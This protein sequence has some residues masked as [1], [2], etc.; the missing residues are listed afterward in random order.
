MNKWLLTVSWIL[1]CCSGCLYQIY[2]LS[3]QYMRYEV[4]TNVEIF[5]K[6]KI[7]LPAVTFCF[8]IIN[9]ID[10]SNERVKA[11]CKQIIPKLASCVNMTADQLIA[12]NRMDH[13]VASDS[14]KTHQILDLFEIP[15]IIMNL[16]VRADQMIPAHARFD[17]MKK[18]LAS[19]KELTD[20]FS[21]TEYIVANFKCITL[22]WLPQHAHQEYWF[23]KR[24]ITMLDAF[25]FIVFDKGRFDRAH[26][27]YILYSV[28]SEQP[29]Y[30]TYGY[31]L[32]TNQADMSKANYEVFESKIMPS[33]FRTN[34]MDYKAATDGR[35]E[36]RASCFDDCFFRLTN[37]VDVGLKPIPNRMEAN[38]FGLKSTTIFHPGNQEVQLNA[39]IECQERCSHKDCHQKWYNIAEKPLS[40]ITRVDKVLVCLLPSSPVVKSVSAAKVTLESYLTDVTSTFGFWLGFSVVS[41]IE[42]M[43]QLGQRLM[44]YLFGLSVNF[45]FCKGNW[46]R[47][48]KKLMFRRIGKNR[49]KL[50]V[51]GVTMP[52]VQSA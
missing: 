24:E 41:L 1:I 49:V 27:M 2:I 51:T 46:C 18:K 47:K 29:R 10:W 4:T 45:S 28:N 36:N 44:T 5:F 34:C 21:V 37:A 6:E 11:K 9:V 13:E 38:D 7:E 52:V 30:G 8:E 26:S 35:F 19:F 20:T 16:T 42:W 23:L 43:Q 14:F 40:N 48:R 33:P 15:D 22:H 32:Q 25:A 3:Q 31:D 39:T 17:Q 12:F 50:G